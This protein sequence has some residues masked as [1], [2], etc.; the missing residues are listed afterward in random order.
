MLLLLCS[1]SFLADCQQ[2]LPSISPLGK[3]TAEVIDRFGPD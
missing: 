1:N 3:V 2:N